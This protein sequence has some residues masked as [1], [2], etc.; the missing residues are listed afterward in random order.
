MAEKYLEF[1]AKRYPLMQ[2]AD[3]VKL[4]YQRTFGVGH[5][6]RDSRS[7]TERLLREI[8]ETAPVPGIP[9]TEPIGNGFARIMLNS[10]D[11]DRAGCDILADCCIRTAAEFHGSMEDFLRDLDFLKAACRGHLF[12]FSPEDLEEYLAGYQAEGYPPVSHSQVY[13]DAYHPAYRVV[14]DVYFGTLFRGL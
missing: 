6:I 7:F 9:L 3:A 10:P 14:K 11:F 2:P 4:L 1:H 12:A 5:L 13:R 8:G